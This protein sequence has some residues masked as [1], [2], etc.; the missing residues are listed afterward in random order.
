VTRCTICRHPERG[1][2][3][4][5]LVQGGTVRDIAGQYGVSKTA[6]DRHRAHIAAPIVQ[7]VAKVEAEH[8]RGVLEQVRHRRMQLARQFEA[9]LED[10]ERK[11]A[12]VDLVREEARLLDLE[13][14]LTGEL[15]PQKKLSVTMQ[16]DGPG[17]DDVPLETRIA[18]KR[19]SLASDEAELARRLAAKGEG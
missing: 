15:A 13:A 1:A 8:Q 16:I 4:A 17:W 12:L 18:L 5:A 19:A 9:G 6:A 10:G 7:A 14:K 2:I 3:D 11:M